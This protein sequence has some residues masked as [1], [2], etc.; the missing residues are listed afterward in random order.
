MHIRHPGTSPPRNP[1]P[2]GAQ[3]PPWKPHRLLAGTFP[4]DIL[5]RAD[6]KQPK[7][8]RCMIAGVNVRVHARME[9]R[10]HGHFI[11]IGGRVPPLLER[12]APTHDPQMPK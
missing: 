9:K 10:V 1:R 3:G 7:E 2:E 5:G 6:E 8:R 11:R 12:E 4:N